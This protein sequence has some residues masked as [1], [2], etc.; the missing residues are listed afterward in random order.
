MSATEA[1]RVIEVKDGRGVGIFPSSNANQSKDNIQNLIKPY[2]TTLK[3]T[4]E[5]N[6]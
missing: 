2:L 5:G 3:V 1:I 6:Y 4:S